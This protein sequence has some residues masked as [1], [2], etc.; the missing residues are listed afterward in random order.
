MEQTTIISGNN[1]DEIWQQVTADMNAGKELLEYEVVLNQDGRKVSLDIDVDPG[2]GFE[3]GYEFTK[4]SA[5]IQKKNDFRFAI[6]H[7][8]FIDTMGKFFGM[9]DVSIGYPAFDERLIIKTNH[10]KKVRAIF[11]DSSIR[12]VFQQLTD[13]TMHIT[14]HHEEGFLELEIQHAITDPIE[15]RKI[16]HA[17]FKILALIDMDGIHDNSSL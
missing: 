1:E 10:K 8:G 16:Y 11:T 9:E 3:S 6:H 5:S 14:H 12:E 4:L 2:G 17:F 7:E 13:F 15:L